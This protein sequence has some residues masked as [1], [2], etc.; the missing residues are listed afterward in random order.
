MKLQAS[1]PPKQES[2]RKITSLA[3]LASKMSVF[4]YPITLSELYYRIGR[5]SPDIPKS[6][7]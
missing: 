3:V 1:R 5:V 7:D 4:A 2:A 6:D